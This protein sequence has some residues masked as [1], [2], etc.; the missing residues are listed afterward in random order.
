MVFGP[1]SSC[2]P[3]FSRY[4]CK[5]WWW[6]ATALAWLWVTAFN[7]WQIAWSIKTTKM[8][9]S[10]L[11]VGT[12][13]WSTHTH[14]HSHEW[15]RNEEW[16]TIG[17]NQQEAKIPATVRNVYIWQITVGAAVAATGTM[18]QQFCFRAVL[19]ELGLLF[20]GIVV[21]VAGIFEKSLKR[22]TTCRPSITSP[23]ITNCCTAS[24]L[25]MLRTQL[26]R[27]SYVLGGLTTHMV[28]WNNG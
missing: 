28:G 8:Y 11:F 7:N 6:V 17:H 3:F 14:T 5:I 1:A 16:W 24:R 22:V 27:G 4:A 26:V 13:G 20:H 2:L 18:Q 10:Q 15:N 25:L 21:A 9:Y 12:F 23:P 19:P